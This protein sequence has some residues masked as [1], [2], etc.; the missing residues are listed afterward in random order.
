M[1]ACSVESLALATP[2]RRARGTTW[3]GPCLA[4]ALVGL[5]LLGSAGSAAAGNP[6][7]DSL[8]RLLRAPLPDTSRVRVFERLCYAY[9]SLRPDSALYYA[10]QGLRLAR[11]IGYRRGEAACLG[12]QGTAWWG[13][14]DLGRALTSFLAARRLSEELGDRRGVAAC[15]GNIS[16]VYSAQ[17]DQRTALRY[18][19]E[20]KALAAANRNQ[21]L[22]TTQ[23]LNIGTSYNLLNQPDSALHYTRQAYRHALRERDEQNRLV[24]LVNL[25]TLYSD[26]RPALA[27]R[28]YR[29]ALPFCRRLGHTEYLCGAYQNMAELFGQ[30][31]RPDS[32]V[33]YARLALVTAQRNDLSAPLLAA[34]GA[35]ATHF[36]SRHQSDSVVHYLQLGAVARDSL[37]NQEKLE[38]VQRLLFAEN[39][40]QQ[41]RQAAQEQAEEARRYNLQLLAL[42]ILILSVSALVLLFSRRL[43][44]TR[45]AGVIG[46]VTLLMVFEFAALFI[47][48]TVERLT[49]NRPVYTLLAM[50][51]LAAGLAP[52]HHR[53]EAW[54]KQRLTPEPAEGPAADLPVPAGPLK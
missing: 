4:S 52:L 50:V 28:Y 48:P 30:Q 36:T 41:E 42:A 5:L 38:S 11:R 25:A 26:E 14:G 34:S 7:T 39:I 9:Y 46:L 21:A 40:R 32:L 47:G 45:V 35:L 23:L 17:G 2:D 53:L 12:N 37:Y 8:T 31:R 1:S 15:L 20:A 13:M 6:E 43:A 18:M 19:F 22:V 3:L 44:Q 27:L 16:Q 49:N 33:R 24:A 29:Q 54:M 10:R 51:A